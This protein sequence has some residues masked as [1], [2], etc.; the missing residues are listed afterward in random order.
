[1]VQAI[2][3]LCLKFP[4]KHRTLVNFLSNILREEG[5]FAFKKAIVDSIF[6]IIKNIPDAKDPGLTHLSEFIEDCEFTY[7]SSQI[8]HL[9]GSEGP[10][11][12]DPS[13]YIRY[14]YNRV[15]LENAAIR[16]SAISA[17]TKFGSECPLLR[18]RV[19]TLLYRCLHD[20]DDEVRDRAT[21]YV[22][23]LEK[24]SFQEVNESSSHKVTD[25]ALQDVESSLH[26]YISGSTVSPYSISDVRSAS[27]RS[28]E[29]H[30]VSRNLLKADHNISFSEDISSSLEQ[31]NL[32]SN[33]LFSAYG[34]V[35]K[36]CC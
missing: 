22:Q 31:S 23:E 20:S 2:Q 11:T 6:C 33:P 21:L 13:K 3:T 10:Q 19:L 28:K 17:L 4:H 14:I 1:V 30:G 16:A 32:L 27:Q 7:L 36:V 9:L 8:L 25:Y 18:S 24:L 5:G 12:T 15:V 29:D 35:F 34:S 26:S